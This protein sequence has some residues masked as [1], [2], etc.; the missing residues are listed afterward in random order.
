MDTVGIIGAGVMGLTVAGKILE[1]GHSLVVYDVM[2]QSREKAQRLGAMVVDTPAEVAKLTNIILLFLPGPKEVTIC[3][4]AHD[5][6]LSAAHPKMIIVDMSTVD[7][8]TSPG[9]GHPAGGP[10]GQRKP[11]AAAAGA[12]SG[13]HQRNGEGPGL[14]LLGHGCHVEMSLQSLGGQARFPA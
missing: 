4:K 12:R 1:A 5:G 9:K 7:P 3:V 2:S 6:L 13:V 10:D 8:G 14:R 11:G